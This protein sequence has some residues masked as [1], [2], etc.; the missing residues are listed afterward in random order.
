MLK[1]PLGPAQTLTA[2]VQAVIEQLTWIKPVPIPEDITEAEKLSD[3]AIVKLFQASSDMQYFEQLFD[4]YKTK[5]YRKVY[6]Y[7]KDELDAEDVTQDI[8][9]KL[10]AKLPKFEFKSQFRTWLY[11]LVVNTC[12]DFIKQKKRK[13]CVPLASESHHQSHESH[14]DAKKFQAVKESFVEVINSSE[15]HEVQKILQQMKP[16]EAHLLQLRFVDDLK[17]EQIG[18]VLSLPL[19]SVKQRL[20]RTRKK[21]VTLY[22]EQF[23]D[24]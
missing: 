7:A 5:I 24:T 18:A 19:N 3:E 6:L 8:F 1:Q 2:K 17:M 23:P 12:L 20:H 22:K 21:F 10:H 16:T 15:G 11:R 13:A 9:I 4:R 14:I